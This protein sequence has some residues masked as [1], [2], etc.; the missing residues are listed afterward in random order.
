MTGTVLLVDDESSWL[1]SFEITLRA[2]GIADVVTC[3]DA[4]AV[5]DLLRSREISAMALDLTMPRVSG[6]ELLTRVVESF[7]GLPVIIVTGINSVEA[8]VRCVKSGAFD[9]FVKT[10]EADR[11]VSGVRRALELSELRRE[12]DRLKESF[13]GGTLRHPEAFAEILTQD[14]T[15][16]SVF[17]YLEAIAPTSQPVLITG[18]SGTG[19]ELVARAIHTLSGRNGRFVTV[20]A[21]GYDEQLFADTLF[22][23]RKG[24]FTGASDTRAGLVERAAEGTLF[25]DEIGDLPPA[26]QIKLLRLLQEREYFPLGSDVA[27]LSTARIVV[28]SHRNLREMQEQG[29]F[30]HD[31]YYRLNTH[32]IH[33]PPLRE[34]RVDVPLLTE[35]FAVEAARELGKCLLEVRSDVYDALAHYTFPGNVR[36]LKAMVFD[37]VSRATSG[38]LGSTRLHE[39]IRERSERHKTGETASEDVPLALSF[40]ARLPTLKECNQLLIQ[41]AL[42]RAGGNQAVAAEWLGIT[43]QAL[44]WRLKHGEGTAPAP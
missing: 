44:N 27:K 19:K 15:M 26:N 4:L 37:A 25:L 12:N 13:L 35:H 2:H 7:P 29:S 20:N 24:A 30:R 17:Q 11:L 18:E 42:R 28:A 14:R 33:L 32:H 3:D 8:A 23:H 1:Q 21:A 22:G 43:R 10:D 34:R 31:L 5:F 41:E 38:Q 36:E 39:L 6:E 16:Q 40:P 9:Y